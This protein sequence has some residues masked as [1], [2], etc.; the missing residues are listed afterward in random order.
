[1]LLRGQKFRQPLFQLRQ[2][3]VLDWSALHM[4]APNEK[5]IKCAERAETKLNSGTAEILPA[6]RTE[7]RPEIVAAERLP[8]GRRLAFVAMPLMQFIQRLP[9]IALCI[10]RC[11]TVSC[12]MLEKQLNPFILN[13]NFRVLRHA[14]SLQGNAW[15]GTEFT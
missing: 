4:S 3:N 14:E 8:I 13:F 2:R 15:E 5:F 6:E 1:H 7:I 11:T 10:D 12:K 9:V